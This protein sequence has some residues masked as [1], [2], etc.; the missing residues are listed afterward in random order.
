MANEDDGRFTIGSAE[1]LQRRFAWTAE[2]WNPPKLNPE[3]IPERLR[4]LIPLAQRWGVTCDITRHD[5]AAKASKAE[6]SHLAASLRGRHHQIE[7]WLNTDENE[8]SEEERAAFQAMVV[9]EMEEC[10]GP[11]LKGLIDWAIRW[12]K[13]DP[14]PNRLHRLKAAYQEVRGWKFNEDYRD[15][16]SEALALIER[17]SQ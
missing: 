3:V 15:A 6:L 8:E 7:D 13:D 16:L 5:V 1:E 17:A 12:Y 9:L 2:N 4:D 11:G 10:D 14:S